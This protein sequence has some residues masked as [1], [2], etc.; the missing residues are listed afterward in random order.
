MAWAGVGLTL[1]N[2]AEE[3]WGLQGT[4]GDREA[5]KGW[6]PRVRRVG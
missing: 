3:V 1:S 2:K 4:D 6:V 5:L